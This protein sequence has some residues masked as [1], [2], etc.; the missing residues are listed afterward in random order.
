[1]PGAPCHGR[2]A[3]NAPRLG[4]MP[5][6]PI[7]VH[8]QALLQLFSV[9]RRLEAADVKDELP[10][11]VHARATGTTMGELTT[12]LAHAARQIH[13]VAHVGGAAIAGGETV[14]DV[15]PWPR[16]RCHVYTRARTGCAM[17]E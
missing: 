2:L 4:L 12:V 1:M 15:L 6:T 8:V 10:V 5:P 17:I 11:L 9:P 7:I 13:R 16:C 3:G 14:D